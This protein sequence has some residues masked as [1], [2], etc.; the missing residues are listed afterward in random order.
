VNLFASSS[1]LIA[2]LVAYACGF[3]T[4]YLLRFRKQ[5]VQHFQALNWKTG[6]LLRFTFQTQEPLSA[7]SE[8]LQGSSE[9]DKAGAINEMLI[10]WIKRDPGSSGLVADVSKLS[11]MLM[12][13][14]IGEAQAML[15]IDGELG[16]LGSNVLVY[17]ELAKRFAS[18]IRGSQM[19][20]D[21][22]VALYL[23][24]WSFGHDAQYYSRAFEIARTIDRFKARWALIPGSVLQ[25]LSDAIDDNS[26]PLS[27]AID[28][29]LPST[30]D[31]IYNNPMI[32]EEGRKMLEDV[33]D[34]FSRIVEALN[35]RYKRASSQVEP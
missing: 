33:L 27:T 8:S 10:D 34:D 9:S 7:S 13:A 31:D 4:P 19:L 1:E 35:S 26:E 18:C 23:Y 25:S 17:R 20:Q 11:S 22:Q 32:H 3:A 24:C 30:L 5:Q 15:F 12:A 29:A 6:D 2:I 21:M 14:G 28:P 16:H